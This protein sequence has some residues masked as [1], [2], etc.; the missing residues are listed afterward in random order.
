MLGSTA[1]VTFAK[2]V[3]TRKPE[4][5]A[6]QV[7]EFDDYR[8]IT[9]Q[10]ANI[11]DEHHWYLTN[12]GDDTYTIQH[13]VNDR[14]LDGYE[15]S[16]NDFTAVTRDFQGND[17]QKWIVR[18]LDTG[19]YTIQHAVNFRYLDAYEDLAND[20]T[21]VTSNP[22]LTGDFTGL[23]EIQDEVGAPQMVGTIRTLTVS[24]PNSDL[25]R[26]E[27]N[28]AYD[29]GSWGPDTVIDA[30]VFNQTAATPWSNHYDDCVGKELFHPQHV[31][32]L[33]N[34][35]G[36]AYFM[37]SQSRAHNGYLSVLETDLGAVDPATDLL[38]ALDNRG[39]TGRYIWQDVYTGER[40][41]TFNPIGN[42][43]HP[44]KMSVVGGVLVVAAQNWDESNP[45]CQYAPGTSTDA[46]LFYDVRDPES[47]R[48]MG[49]ITADD[50]GVDEV[51]NLELIRT[52][53][54][55]YLLQAGGGD[56]KTTWIA[57]QL[58]PQQLTT[59]WTR[60]SGSEGLA[61]Q[62]GAAFTSYQ[63]KTTI[64]EEFS[65]PAGTERILFFDTSAD[66]GR[67][68]FFDEYVGRDESL[69]KASSKTFNVDLPGAERHWNT[70]SLYITEYGSPVMYSV[71]SEEGSD[72]VLFQGFNPDDIISSPFFI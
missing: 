2:Q 5:Q 26:P 50:L 49:A 40:N 58:N 65:P 54:D 22:Q 36:R 35:D 15:D 48:Y 38:V 60:V 56:S 31:V 44:G 4:T 12:V 17:S 30:H 52:P 43:N 68:V 7:D 19:T 21:A 9:S 62:H 72:Y 13:V 14:Y 25:S 8:A 59:T 51:A 18:K 29:S 6:K 64:S 61:H 53:D 69:V 32:R 71:Q 57:P 41:G 24:D 70:A 46:V 55:Q 66:D 47:P 11:G 28:I 33:P 63:W 67:V 23:L 42:W 34:K 27:N 39:T 45:F 10:V 3:S 16:G 20:F 1:R 37:V